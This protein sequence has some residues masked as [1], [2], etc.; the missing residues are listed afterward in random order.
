MK[1]MQKRAGYIWTD[2]KTNIETAKEIYITPVLGKILEYNT[3]WSQHVNRTAHNRLP[4]ILKNY[5]PTDRRNHGTPLQRLLD[6]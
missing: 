3:N 5:R 2:Y 4:R 1:Y 6:A